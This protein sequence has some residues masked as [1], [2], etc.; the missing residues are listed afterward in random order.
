M[1][2]TLP[3]VKV[4]RLRLGVCGLT[5]DPTLRENMTA[6]QTKRSPATPANP[7]PWLVLGPSHACVYGLVVAR[8]KAL[9][10]AF[11]ISD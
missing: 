8:Q 9:Q 1:T 11:P 4:D 2:L 3:F 6:G 5:V 10:W 7:H